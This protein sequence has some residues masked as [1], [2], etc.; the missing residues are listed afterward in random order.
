MAVY[1]FKLQDELLPCVLF[2]K[3]QMPDVRVIAAVAVTGISSVRAFAI[4]FLFDHGVMGKRDLAGI[5]G[6]APD[7]GESIFIRPEFPTVIPFLLF[8][9]E[10]SPL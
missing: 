4:R 1:A 8:H 5:L 6:D 10:G 9:S 7:E 3:L 2:A